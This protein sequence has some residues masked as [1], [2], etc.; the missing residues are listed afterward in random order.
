MFD[1]LCFQRRLARIHSKRRAEIRRVTRLSPKTQSWDHER[2]VKSVAEHT[3]RMAKY[4]EDIKETTTSYLLEQKEKLLI[5]YPRL[6]DI[7]AWTPSSQPGKHHIKPEHVQSLR[8]AIRK[9]QKERSE[10]AR[11]WMV[12]AAGVIGAL[13][14]LIGVSIGLLA[15]LSK[16]H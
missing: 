11:L 12:A 6:D 2:I 4:T 1:E 10:I 8:D 9:E 7:S 16:S 3:A 14:G 5:Y 13:T 15:Y